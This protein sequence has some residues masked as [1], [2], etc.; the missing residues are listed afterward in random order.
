MLK[1]RQ[2][3]ANVRAKY[4]MGKDKAKRRQIQGKGNVM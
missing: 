4:I 2:G 3:K 1:A